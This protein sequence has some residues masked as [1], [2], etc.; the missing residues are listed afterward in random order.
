MRYVLFFTLFLPLL[1]HAGLTIDNCRKFKA[2]TTQY[3]LCMAE[4]TLTVSY[5]ERIRNLDIQT[6]CRFAIIQQQRRALANPAK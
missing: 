1:A 4:A 5:C 3:N 6:H 2:D